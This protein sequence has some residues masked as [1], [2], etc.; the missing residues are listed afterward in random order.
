MKCQS[1]FPGKSKKNIRLLTAEYAQRIVNLKH[2]I[3]VEDSVYS[4]FFKPVVFRE[5]KTYHSAVFI[6][7]FLVV[8]EPILIYWKT[9]FLHQ[10]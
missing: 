6:F 7:I 3:I 1:L 9:K 10:C 5:N 2:K 8:T 4:I